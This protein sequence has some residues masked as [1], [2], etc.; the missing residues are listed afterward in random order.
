MHIDP[1]ATALKEIS[2]TQDLLESLLHS[3]ESFDYPRARLA[4]KELNDKVRDL[5]RIRAKFEEMQKARQ[6]NIYVVDFKAEPPTSPG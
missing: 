2:E 4:L 1:L 6:P 5:A 3:S